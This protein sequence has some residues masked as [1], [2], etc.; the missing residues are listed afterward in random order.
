MGGSRG[1]CELQTLAFGST[2]S[3]GM[4]SSVMLITLNVTHVTALNIST[5]RYILLF[6]DVCYK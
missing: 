4:V 2:G 6:E 5:S 3:N 1:T